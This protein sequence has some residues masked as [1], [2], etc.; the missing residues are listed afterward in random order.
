MQGLVLMYAVKEGRKM[1]NIITSNDASKLQAAVYGMQG[2]SL[3]PIAVNSLGKQIFSSPSIAQITAEDFDIRN[4][5]SASDS[6]L[7]TAS[8]LDIRNLSGSQDSIKL[9][10]R[11]SAEASESGTIVALGSRNFVTRNEA[12]ISA[13][14][15]PSSIKAG[16][17]SQ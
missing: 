15:T 12:C 1:N 13:T 3:N 5:S 9:Y 16:S 7:I 4:L 2:T 11:A 14:A 17:Q 8:D 6:L 10:N